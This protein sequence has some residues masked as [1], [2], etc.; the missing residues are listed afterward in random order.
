[1]KHIIKKTAALLITFSPGDDTE[2]KFL[3]TLTP[4]NLV[5]GI[6]TLQGGPKDLDGSYRVSEITDF[7]IEAELPENREAYQ[8]WKNEA[9][10][11]FEKAYNK[12]HSIHMLAAFL[13]FYLTRTTLESHNLTNRKVLGEIGL[14]KQMEW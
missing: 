4:D 2:Y 5:V 11:I 14:I 3:L 1:M 7:F 10:K 8:T 13:A 12:N 6:T 9:A